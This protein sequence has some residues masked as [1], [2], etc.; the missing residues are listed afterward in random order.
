MQTPA[1][2]FGLAG[3]LALVLLF[4]SAQVMAQG[5][6]R[7]RGLGPCGGWGRDEP[8][9]NQGIEWTRTQGGMR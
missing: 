6:G 9:R 3:L 8:K 5:R 2:T 4:A 1:K 7:G